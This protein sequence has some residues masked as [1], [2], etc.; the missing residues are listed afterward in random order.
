MPIGL[1]IMQAGKIN[2]FTTVTS[3]PVINPTAGN[4]FCNDVTTFTVEVDNIQPISSANTL[5]VSNGISL[6]QANIVVVST[7]GFPSSGSIFIGSINATVNYTGTSGG[8]TF[9]GCTGGSGT[10][11]ASQA[12]TFTLPPQG[13]V[14]L[15]DANDGYVP[16]NGVGTLSPSGVSSSRA[17]LTPIWEVGNPNVVAFYVGQE[18]GIADI[19]HQF[20][21]SQSAGVSYIIKSVTTAGTISGPGSFNHLNPVAYNVN[22]LTI[23]G[24]HPSEGLVTLFATQVGNHGGNAF[25][26]GAGTPT[27]GIISFNITGSTFLGGVNV[28]LSATYFDTA[29]SGCYLSCTSSPAVVSPS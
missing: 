13:T 6:P 23:H 9:T 28:T 24:P 19:Y 12:V 2:V 27:N 16:T 10:L 29:S 3:I 11:I 15:A 7:A 17:V 1:G 21:P 22:I 5:M 8:N 14:F 25:V 26:V 20:K 4:A 18:G